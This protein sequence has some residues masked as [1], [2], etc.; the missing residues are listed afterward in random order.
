MVG[1]E[2][3]QKYREYDKI[4]NKCMYQIQK[5]VQR[6]LLLIFTRFLWTHP[7]RS[8]PIIE[9]RLLCFCSRCK[10]LIRV[11][12]WSKKN[13]IIDWEN[14]IAYWEESEWS[15][16]LANKCRQWWNLGRVQPQENVYPH[17][18]L[19]TVLPALKGYFRYKTI[20]CSKVALD[21]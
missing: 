20:F 14:I 21:V 12:I 16:A 1:V 5:I 7:L 19:K 10:D 3:L 4:R 11:C 17:W 13:L 8:K 6:S 15:K 9:T 18:R 2:N